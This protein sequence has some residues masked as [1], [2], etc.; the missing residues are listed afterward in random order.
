MDFSKMS[1]DELLELYKEVDTRAKAAAWTR[2]VAYNIVDVLVVAELDNVL[3]FIDVAA[4]MAHSAKCV[5]TDVFRVTRIWDNIIAN[6]CRESNIQVPTVVNNQRVAFEGA[7]VKPTIP[8]KY[9]WIASF[10]IK[11]L[12]PSII[13]Q[14]NISPETILPETEF[15]PMSA[16]EMTNFDGNYDE[17]FKHAKSLNA[18][19]CANGALF[20]REK[21]G[22][23]PA[24]IDV[25]MDGRQADQK[26]MFNWEHKLERAKAR[27]N[28]L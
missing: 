1:D 27:L 2:F 11:S 14:Q 10:D 20:S 22:T 24:L 17:A 5:Y 18:S 15:T 16:A 12:Y 4:S 3:G 8:G 21:V 13:V 9:Q 19:L 23:I 25:Y 26:E 7:F 28:S 6:Y